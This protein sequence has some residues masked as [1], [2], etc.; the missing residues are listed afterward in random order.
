MQMMVSRRSLETATAILTGAFGAAVV[1]SSYGNGI[2]WS[3]A[4]V[5]SGTF[6]FIVGLIILSGSVFNLVQGWLQARDIVLRPSE[7]KRL[8]LL[9]IPAAVYVGVIPFIGM[10]L[11]SIGYVFGALAWHKRGS[12]IY[13]GVAAISTALALYLIFERTFQISLPRGVLGDFIGF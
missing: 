6:P 7:L 2:G 13:S 5:D 8:G 11:A 4:G 12:F 3:A 1:I 9:F 10:Y